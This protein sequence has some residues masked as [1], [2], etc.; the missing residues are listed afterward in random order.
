M[1]ENG[2]DDQ[3]ILEY[4]AGGPTAKANLDRMNKP[5]VIG[6]PAYIEY[7]AVAYNIA[8][9][10]DVELEGGAFKDAEKALSSLVEQVDQQFPTVK[11]WDFKYRAKG[12]WNAED[13]VPVTAQTP[14]NAP[15]ATGSCVYNTTSHTDLTSKLL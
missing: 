14:A 8:D 4:I 9:N 10:L 6:K 12:H 7:V 5:S 15:T 13:G 3:V 2:N 11:T 1:A